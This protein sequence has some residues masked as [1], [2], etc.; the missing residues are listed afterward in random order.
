MKKK[1]DEPQVVNTVEDVQYE[2][3]GG[4]LA[5]VGGGGGVEEADDGVVFSNPMLS[6]LT[7]RAY[8]QVERQLFTVIIN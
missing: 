1:K 8:Q 7:I 4:G 3:G 6:E 2:V 5:A